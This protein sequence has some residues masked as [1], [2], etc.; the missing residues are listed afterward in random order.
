LAGLGG[1]FATLAFIL[2]LILFFSGL[3]VA[4][5]TS[6]HFT[7]TF[8]ISISTSYPVVDTHLLHLLCQVHILEE[9]VSGVGA[10]DSLA[11]LSV[12]S[13]ILLVSTVGVSVELLS[14]WKSPGNGQQNC[15]SMQWFLLFFTW[16]RFWLFLRGE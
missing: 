5:L 1:S 14:S 7:S 16:E 12:L 8:L 3:W 4:T 10:S 6:S 13:V 9:V 2:F 11:L 15:L